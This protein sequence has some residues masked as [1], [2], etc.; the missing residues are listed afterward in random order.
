M[1]LTYT[2]L[3]DLVRD[4]VLENSSIDAVNAASIDIHLGDSVSTEVAYAGMVDLKAKQAPSMEPREIDDGGFM[5]HPGQFCLVNTREVF[6]LPDDL[7]CE[8]KL[9]S[10]LARAG[11]NH[12]LAGWADPGFHGAT[13]TLELHNA[14]QYHPLLLRPGMPIG[15]L[16]FWRGEP[17]PSQHSYRVKGR[18]NGQRE[19]TGSKGV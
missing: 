15:Q 19:A 7:A 11:L 14:L 1:L 10:S 5:L 2:A 8:Y 4:G 16:V 12:S 18:Y 9:K 6:H 17:V 13:L 3:C